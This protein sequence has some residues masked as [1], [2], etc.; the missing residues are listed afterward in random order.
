[1]EIESL[2]GGCACGAIRY[3][4]A[5]PPL[6]SFK[7]HCRDCQRMSGSGYMGVMWVPT[8]S[9]DISGVFEAHVLKAVSGRE[10]NRGFCAKCGSN[11]ILRSTE[12]TQ[13]TQIVASSLDDPK[14]FQPTAELWTASAQPWD[15]IDE[16]LEVFETQPSDDQVMQM[17]GIN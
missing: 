14:L 1:M 11:V 13:M 7:C 12:V 2:S 17:L 9:I 6:F 15:L 10:L 3:K 4:A 8:E 16:S 5:A